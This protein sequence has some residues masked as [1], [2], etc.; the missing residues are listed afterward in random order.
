MCLFL[1]FFF[2]SYFPSQPHHHHHHHNHNHQNHH[3]TISPWTNAPIPKI[4]WKTK[5]HHQSKTIVLEKPENWYPAAPM[6]DA[7]ADDDG[8]LFACCWMAS[9]EALVAMGYNRQ[10][11]EE[12]LTFTR[13][14]DVFATYLLLGRK[15]TDVSCFSLPFISK[16]AKIPEQKENF[17]FPYF[18]CVSIFWLNRLFFIIIFLICYVFRFLVYSMEFWF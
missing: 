14:D 1:F 17:R 18:V 16:R 8:P 12:S 15:S 6:D 3:I 10:D 5:N 11:I 2:L 7:D 13:Y 9:A 4:Q